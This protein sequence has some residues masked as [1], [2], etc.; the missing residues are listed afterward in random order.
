MN[1]AEGVTPY[2]EAAQYI[3]CKANIVAFAWSQ[4]RLCTYSLF[5]VT[6]YLETVG[7][8]IIVYDMNDNI[9]PLCDIHDR[10]RSRVIATR[11]VS[12]VNAFVRHYN[13]EDS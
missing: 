2:G 1:S 6:Y 10:P 5:E 11:V 9:L 3:G 8:R 7:L 4:A 13:G 12:D